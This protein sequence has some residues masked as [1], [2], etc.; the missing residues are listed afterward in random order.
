[1][2]TKKE[3]GIFKNIIISKIDLSL[4]TKLQSDGFGGNWPDLTTM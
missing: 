1:M 2:F 4:E 3:Q